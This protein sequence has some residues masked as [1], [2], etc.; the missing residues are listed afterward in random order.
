ME[1]L[2]NHPYAF[3][4]SENIV[5]NVA[6][7]S[8]HNDLL[9][10]DIKVSQEEIF[11]TSLQAISCCE[12]GSTNPEEKFLGFGNGWLTLKPYPSWVLNQDETAWIAPI[13][14]P[15]PSE[16]YYWSEDDLNWIHF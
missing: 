5:I 8:E 7:F 12:E 15:E 14:S 2:E 3:I 6:V 13:P 10:N 4:N 9:V 11:N 16:E 1:H